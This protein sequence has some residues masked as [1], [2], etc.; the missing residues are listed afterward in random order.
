[1]ST[2][3]KIRASSTPCSGS[4]LCATTRQASAYV[5]IDVPA[6]VVDT[7]G[8]RVA[9]SLT[10]SSIYPLYRHNRLRGDHPQTF[11]VPS[12]RGSTSVATAA[13]AG[14]IFLGSYMRKSSGSYQPKKAHLVWNCLHRKL[15]IPYYCGRRPDH[16]DMFFFLWRHRD[17]DELARTSPPPHPRARFPLGCCGL[18][19]TDSTLTLK[20]NWGPPHCHSTHT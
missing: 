17:H 6:P 3:V 13:F 12:M 9:P 19:E 7:W 14:G 15:S 2:V 4:T 10:M 20:W 16:D 11:S 8:V 18:A 5:M 1:M